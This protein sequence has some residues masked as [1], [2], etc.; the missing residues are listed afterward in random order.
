MDKYFITIEWDDSDILPRGRCTSHVA[1]YGLIS[2][3]QRSEI[4]H[5]M[6]RYSPFDYVDSN[7]YETESDYKDMLETLKNNGSTIIY[8]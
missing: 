6:N 3:R 8:E 5:F 7:E 2:S 4:K 1:A